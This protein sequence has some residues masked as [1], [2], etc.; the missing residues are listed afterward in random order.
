MIATRCTDKTNTA[1]KGREWVGKKVA[2]VVD[3][4]ETDEET[5][6]RGMPKST[7]LGQ[8]TPGCDQLGSEPG[9]L[10]FRRG[11]I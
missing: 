9:D 7:P 1:E 10:V 2:I 4:E 3:T 6:H 11:V 5:A 8:L